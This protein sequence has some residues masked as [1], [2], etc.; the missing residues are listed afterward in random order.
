MGGGSGGGDG[1]R[2][3]GGGG[4][5]G[6]GTG[7]NVG[8]IDPLVSIEATI[9][10]TPMRGEDHLPCLRQ[11]IPVSGFICNCPNSS[12]TGAVNNQDR[13]PWLKTGVTNLYFC[14]ANDS[15]DITSTTLFEALARHA[16]RKSDGTEGADVV[17]DEQG[18]GEALPETSAASANIFHTASIHPI[19]DIRMFPRFIE[20]AHNVRSF[21]SIG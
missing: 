4:G 10:E 18:G 17:V 8:G 3:G 13:V 7:G 1:G 16:Q 19:T 14:N 20:A 2:G 21:R 5:V 15:V 6:G 11:A 9:T 12:E